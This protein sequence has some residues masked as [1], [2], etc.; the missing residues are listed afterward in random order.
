[1]REIKSIIQAIMPK[2]VAPPRRGGRGGAVKRR[3]R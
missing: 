2:N 1:M 3:E